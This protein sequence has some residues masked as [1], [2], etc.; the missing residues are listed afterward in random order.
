MNKIFY[1]LIVFFTLSACY[2][3]PASRYEWDFNDQTQKITFEKNTNKKYTINSNFDA[4]EFV[5]GTDS[6]GLRFDGYSTFIKEELPGKI[7][8][9]LSVT[10]WVAMETYPTDTAGFFSL[11]SGD[12]Q[13]WISAS[14]N[15]FGKPVLVLGLNGKENY[16]VADTIIPKFKW[17]NV[18][19]SIFNNKVS[20]LINGK[21]VKTVPFSDK[22]FEK[23][24]DTITIG[25]E[26]K[27]K[28]LE[29]LF[30]LTHINGIVDEV[31]IWDGPMN[32]RIINSFGHCIKAEY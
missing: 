5:N 16:F 19:L 32:H 10:A 8:Y 17:F 6:Y 13:N 7:D 30:P 9:P 24:F 26:E 3:K 11:S 22:A 4:P 12:S 14:V 25:R 18:G 21:E 23:G 27:E 20:L 28:Y 15:R 1:L 2:Y 29:N 31:K